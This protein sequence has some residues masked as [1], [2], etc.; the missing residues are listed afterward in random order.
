MIKY[1][2]YEAYNGYLEP[3]HELSNIRKEDWSLNE[4]WLNNGFFRVAR[5]N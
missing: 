4:V 1:T 2:Y 5:R 3:E